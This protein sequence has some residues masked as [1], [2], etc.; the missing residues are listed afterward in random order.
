MTIESIQA[1]QACMKFLGL[2]LDQRESKE[3]QCDFRKG[4][5]SGVML[6]QFLNDVHAHQGPYIAF[7]DTI[8]GFGLQYQTFKPAF[9]EFSFEIRREVGI[10]TCSDTNFEFHL[11]FDK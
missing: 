4:S 1:I 10:L 9:Q 2:R 7:D 6:V 8:K 11:R 3:I 5:A